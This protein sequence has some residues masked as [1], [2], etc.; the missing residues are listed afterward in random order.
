MSAGTTMSHC[1]VFLHNYNSNSIWDRW[2]GGRRSPASRHVGSNAEG[3][4]HVT[5]SVSAAAAATKDHFRHHVMFLHF[6]MCE[7]R[8]RIINNMNV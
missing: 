8:S 3:I 7:K 6:C 5:L 4:Q 2:R 1:C